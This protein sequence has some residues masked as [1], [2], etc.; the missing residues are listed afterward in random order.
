MCFCYIFIWL[1]M[2]E[3]LDLLLT[4]VLDQ[5]ILHLSVKTF[6]DSR[7]QICLM[8]KCTVS[9]HLCKI[10]VCLRLTKYKLDQGSLDWSSFGAHQSMIGAFTLAQTNRTKIESRLWYISTNGRCKSGLIFLSFQSTC[11]LW[12]IYWAPLLYTLH[13]FLN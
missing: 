4:F 6:S 9:L 3:A 13:F 5:P 11:W 2:D 10:E 7:R 12:L 8:Q 1:Y